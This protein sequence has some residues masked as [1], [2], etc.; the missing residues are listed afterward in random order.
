MVIHGWTGGG[1]GFIACH[2]TWQRFG[3][4]VLVSPLEL[5]NFQEEEPMGAGAGGF[6]WFWRCVFFFFSSAFDRIFIGNII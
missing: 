5:K 4:D 1:L 2:G 6:G 3:R